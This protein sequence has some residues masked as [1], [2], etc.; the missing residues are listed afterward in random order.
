MRPFFSETRPGREV[1]VGN[2]KLELP[3]LYFRD[4]SFGALFSA[5]L[6]ALRALMPSDKLHPIPSLR[7][8][9]GFLYIAAFD[10][11][12]TSI[13]PYGELAVVVPAVHGR[14]PPPLVP[15]LLEASWPGF[16]GVVLHLPVTRRE[17]RDGGRVLWGYTK[18]IANMEF[19]NTPELHECR[20]EEGGRHILTLHVTKR[21]VAMPDRRPI[22]TYSVKDGSLIRTAIPQSAIVR[23][24]VGA[25]GSFLELG[26][27]HPVARSIQA[28][29]VDPKP[30]MTRYYLD[31]HAILP[32]GEIIERGVRALDGYIGADI[33]RGELRTT[34]MPVT[35]H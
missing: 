9:R 27:S 32:E 4:D 12:E 18:F 20:L 8:G 1:T 3:V 15:S 16:G 13:E 26:D 24:A 22:I 31:R 11:L 23:A 29:D 2:S 28:L 35:I 30:L 21:G 34:Y 10:Y 17:A 7:R 6:Q 33:A 25:G 5:D 19:Q 14:R